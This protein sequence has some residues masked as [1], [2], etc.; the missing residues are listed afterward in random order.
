MQRMI[1]FW[2][3]DTPHLLGGRKRD[4]EKK[5]EQ[6]ERQEIHVYDGK[7]EDKKEANK[8]AKGERHTGTFLKCSS[9]LRLVSFFFKIAL[10]GTARMCLVFLFCMF[11][12]IVEGYIRVCT[13]N[14]IYVFVLS[15]FSRSSFLP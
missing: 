2:E 1:Y 6:M 9:F 4:K 10:E 5:R 14:F 3:K 12:C 7:D 13:Y 8:R 15:L 11:V